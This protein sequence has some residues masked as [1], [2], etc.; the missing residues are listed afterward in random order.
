[1]KHRRGNNLLDAAI[2]PI[3]YDAGTWNLCTVNYFYSIHLWG[4]QNVPCCWLGP[5]FGN[6]HCFGK[7]SVAFIS[8]STSFLGLFV[9]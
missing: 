8:A 3:G 9:L 6:W 1:M 2:I 4:N 5:R 7:C